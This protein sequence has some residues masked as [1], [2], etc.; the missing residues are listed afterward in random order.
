MNIKQAMAK[1]S[2]RLEMAVLNDAQIVALRTRVLPIFNELYKESGLSW[3]FKPGKDGKPLVNKNQ[4][5]SVWKANRAINLTRD[6]LEAVVGKGTPALRA[7]RLNKA[8]KDNRVSGITMPKVLTILSLRLTALAKFPNVSKE[9]RAALTSFVTDPTFK[10]LKGSW[11]FIIDEL[12]KEVPLILKQH[13][14]LK[15]PPPYSYDKKPKGGPSPEALTQRFTEYCKSKGFK[16]TPV[17]D[18]KYKYYEDG[19]IE[20]SKPAGDDATINLVCVPGQGIAPTF[21]V[22]GATFSWGRLGV[23]SGIT[24]W[25]DENT[26]EALIDHCI[27]ECEV[28]LAKRL[29]QEKNGTMIDFGGRKQLLLPAKL[30]EVVKLLKSGRTYA[31]NPSGFGTQYLYTT[32]KPTGGFYAPQKAS[33]QITKLVGKQVYYTTHDLD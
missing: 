2:K 26:V 28:A 27:E 21:K 17:A 32:V 31:I 24:S 10:L 20:A 23:D 3:T 33:D 25:G 8:L 29:E 9:G 1:V 5:D 6:L 19:C 4:S 12:T 13:H 30:A 15:A 11:S 14:L 18:S 7:S 16:I 22:K